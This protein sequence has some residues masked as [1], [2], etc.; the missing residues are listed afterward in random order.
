MGRAIHTNLNARFNCDAL[1]I[2][3]FKNSWAAEK[4]NTVMYCGMC[5]FEPAPENQ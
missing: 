2:A 5:L 1:K 3:V 4:A